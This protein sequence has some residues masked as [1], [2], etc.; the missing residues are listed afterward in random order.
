MKLISFFIIA[1]LFCF[2]IG[3]ATN[4]VVTKGAPIDISLLGLLEENKTTATEV[5][6]IFG[7]PQKEIFKKDGGRLWVYFYAVKGELIDG[8]NGAVQQYE[9]YEDCVTLNFNKDGTL[10]I[11]HIVIS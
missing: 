8:N 2:L 4:L 3:C 11:M 10:K 6:K 1:L 9:G 5:T 7:A